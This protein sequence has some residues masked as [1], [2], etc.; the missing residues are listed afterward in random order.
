MGS[1]PALPFFW[2]GWKGQNPSNYS[3]KIQ[4]K[5]AKNTQKVATQ[6]KNLLEI[7]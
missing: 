6:V 7:Y 1:H 2:S 3:L 5:E 4:Q